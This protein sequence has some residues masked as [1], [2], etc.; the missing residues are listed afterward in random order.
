VAIER[1]V[2]QRGLR[3]LKLVLPAMLVAGGLVVAPMVLPVLP[4]EKTDAYVTAVTAGVLGDPIGIT[5]FFHG[6]RGWENQAKVVAEVFHRLTPEEQADCIIFAG[7]Y[8]EA[9]ALDY[10]GPAL[11]L[12]PATCWH[13]NNYFWGP[14]AKSGNVSIYIGLDRE[15]L[16]RNFGEVQLAATI[17][18]QEPVAPG[19]DHVPVYICR[20][21][22]FD[23]KKSWRKRSV[24]PPPR[25]GTRPAGDEFA[26]L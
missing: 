5:Y 9:G 4:I 14:P 17:K 6:A 24:N 20:K 26:V 1:W 12:P 7:N 19:E 16:G 23:L 15:T 18:A 2:N 11:G 8:G 10:Y 21:P 25:Q 13:L 22:R 3:R